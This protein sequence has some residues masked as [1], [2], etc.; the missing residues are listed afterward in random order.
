[1]SFKASV[2]VSSVPPPLER[3]APDEPAMKFCIT[4]DGDLLEL[5]SMNEEYC[6]IVKNPKDAASW[7]FLEL[8]DLVALSTAIDQEIK[9]VG[10]TLTLKSRNK[11]IS[12]TKQPKGT[13]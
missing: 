4:R 12:K 8:R 13:I 11:K 1:M 5:R 7:I 9:R 6:M 10:S 2:V 3:L